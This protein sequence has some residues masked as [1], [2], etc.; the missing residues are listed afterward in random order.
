[1][2]AWLFYAVFAV[3]VGIGAPMLVACVGD[4]VHWL[5]GRRR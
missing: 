3:A 4:A 5:K 1:M 2:R